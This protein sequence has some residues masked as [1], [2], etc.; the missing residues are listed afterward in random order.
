MEVV[1]KIEGSETDHNDKPREEARI[2]SVTLS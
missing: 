2:E 1:D